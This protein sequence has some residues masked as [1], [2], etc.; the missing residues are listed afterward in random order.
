MILGIIVI[1]IVLLICVYMFVET[2]RQV[3]KLNKKRDAEI[4]ETIYLLK[5][6]E[7]NEIQEDYKNA[8]RYAIRELE[9]L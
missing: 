5:V 9:K 8:L 7:E 1:I 4:D 6:L 2:I 3:I